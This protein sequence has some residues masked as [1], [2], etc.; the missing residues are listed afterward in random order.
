MFHV[1]RKRF[2]CYE[3]FLSMYFVYIN[4]EYILSRKKTG[5]KVVVTTEG[6]MDTLNDGKSL[7]F[8]YRNLSWNE[9]SF[10][11]SVVI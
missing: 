3:E 6:N 11:I 7:Y 10:V 4:K 9:L 1:L 5:E 2:S 8:W